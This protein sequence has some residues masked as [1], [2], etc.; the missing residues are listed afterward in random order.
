[1]LHIV[2]IHSDR[3][4]VRLA[5]G[6]ILVLPTDGGRVFKQTQR[7][8]SQI[9]CLVCRTHARIENQREVRPTDS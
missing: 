6:P 7:N 1:M 9:L 3:R 2:R 5:H 4:H 8:L